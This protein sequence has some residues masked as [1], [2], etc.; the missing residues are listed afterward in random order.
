VRAPSPSPAADPA[1]LPAGRGSRSRVGVAAGLA[2]GCSSRA[3]ASRRSSRRSLLLDRGPR[4]RGL[5]PAAASSRSR[6]RALRSS[7]AARSPDSRIAGLPR[8]SSITAR[9]RSRARPTHR[10]PRRG[11]RATTSARARLSGL[12]V[13]RV[14]LRR[15]RASRSSAPAAAG[16]L[17][18]ADVRRRGREPRR[19]STSSSTRSSPS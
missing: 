10:S 19:L 18:A 1:R 2:N 9:P 12:R 3:P 17:V 13:D 8:R 14:R 16:L 6:A 11:D 5:A 7:G 15:L 4:P